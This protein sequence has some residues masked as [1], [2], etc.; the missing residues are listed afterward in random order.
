MVS[1]WYKSLY[2]SRDHN[3]TVCL[4]YDSY[5]S[6]DFSTLQN[7]TCLYVLNINYE[8]I[9]KCCALC[10]IARNMYDEIYNSVN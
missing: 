3:D 10:K 8:I 4:Q 9:I 7:F 5:V 6:Q 1:L 2:I